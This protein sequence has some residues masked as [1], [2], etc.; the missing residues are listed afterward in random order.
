M[1]EF[2]GQLI[3]SLIAAIGAI[4]GSFLLIQHD[5]ESRK[6]EKRRKVRA[7]LIAAEPSF[8]KL[9]DDSTRFCKEICSYYKSNNLNY[10]SNEKI[11]YFLSNTPVYK[12]DIGNIDKLIE[13][14]SYRELDVVISIIFVANVLSHRHI[15]KKID[16]EDYFEI[17]FIRSNYL[18]SWFIVS[19][20]AHNYNWLRGLTDVT[21]SEEPKHG[22][23]DDIF[24]NEE[25]MKIIYAKIVRNYLLDRNRIPTP[26]SIPW[27]RA[28]S[29]YAKINDS[30]PRR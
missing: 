19:Q 23:D 17:D 5:I 6:D 11:E 18:L 29:N 16:Y 20:I 2:W 9:A 15:G 8:R 4:C 7:L 26:V 25:Q 28:G 3:G 24:E 22:Y 21:L 10:K 14:L 27:Y 1:V 13:H 30:Q 12:Y